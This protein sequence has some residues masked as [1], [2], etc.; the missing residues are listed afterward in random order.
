MSKKFLHPSRCFYAIVWGVTSC[1]AFS[2]FFDCRLNFNIFWLFI[3]SVCC[4]I[5]CLRPTKIALV[6]AFLSSFVLTSFRYA[7]LFASRDLIGQLVGQSITL[8]GRVSEDPASK[9]GRSV[10]RLDQLQLI[11]SIP[12]TSNDL[13]ENNQNPVENNVQNYPEPVDNYVDKT[14]QNLSGTSYVQLDKVYPDLERSDRI[15]VQG[16]AGAGFGVFLTSM[17]RSELLNIDRDADGDPL[18]RLKNWFAGLVRN[19]LPSP[20]S[21]LGLG[22]LVGMKS[23]LP[24][25]LS[26]T[27][28]LVGMTHVVVASGAHLGILVS[29]AKKIFGRISKFAGL[30]FA[31]LLIFIFASI[32]GFTPSMTR[33]SLVSFLSLAFGYIG[34]RFS[35][36]RLLSLT[37]A[38]TLL[39]NPLGFLNLGWQLSFASFF[40]I[41]ILAPRL[42]KLFYGGKTVP[43][44]ASMLLISLATTLA[45]A[46]ILIY[47]FGSISLLSFIANLIILPTLPYAMLLV[48]LTGAT[49]F[50]PFLAAIIA[51]LATL[52]LD[53]HIA[54]VN[55]LSTKTMFIIELPASN[56][57][58]FCLYLFIL[59]LLILPGIFKTFRRFR[60]E[61]PAYIT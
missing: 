47:N 6:I 17:Y 49:S 45:C 18:A 56:P 33:A 9:S 40:G 35:P 54:V 38:I 34:R 19:Y 48:F 51:K 15:T 31:S 41:L 53:L 13:V 50:L 25:S 8:I 16:E 42:T 37:A 11:S 5:A 36:F 27:L 29:S 1:I 57:Y 43:W 55:Y 22:Y 60:S 3:A 52:L 61:R 4:L 58:I 14:V 2:T 20:E 10:V 32:V 12:A 39:I 23:G 44:L 21:E 28:Q 30:F 26:E 7:P 59:L 46:P 24:D